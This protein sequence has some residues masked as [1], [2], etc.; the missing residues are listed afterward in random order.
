M[1]HNSS[2]W[3]FHLVEPIPGPTIDDAASHIRDLGV[4]PWLLDSIDRMG[5]TLM[6]GVSVV[7]FSITGPKRLVETIQENHDRHTGSRTALPTLIKAFA[8]YAA[9]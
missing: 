4:D 2:R 3:T 5:S 8:S 7:E 1:N 6:H 9:P